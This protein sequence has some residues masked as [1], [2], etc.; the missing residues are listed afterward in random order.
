MLAKFRKFI[1]S[2]IALWT[3]TVLSG[4]LFLALVIIVGMIGARV[5]TSDVGAF[6]AAAAAATTL[7][8]AKEV[9]GGWIRRSKNPAASA[10][11]PR[12]AEGLV[13]FAAEPR[14]RE[15][16]LSNLD[17]RFDE[18][19]ASGKSLARAKFLYTCRALRSVAGRLWT[20]AKRI[21]I[22]G[23]IIAFFRRFF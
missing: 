4:L 7:I 3:R 23:L 22:V 9:W 19:L 14:Y 8:A 15:T 10:E 21:G 20:L 5:T 17:E 6:T 12:F 13:V 18:D 16:L 2:D 11:P 1:E